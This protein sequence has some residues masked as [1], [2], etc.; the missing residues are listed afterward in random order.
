MEPPELSVEVVR[1]F[2]AELDPELRP[3]VLSLRQR[4]LARPPLGSVTI[5][6]IRARASAEFAEWNCDPEPVALVTDLTASV[7]HRRI[8]LRLYDPRPGSDTG[9]LVYLHGG[10]WMIG[11]LGLE[12]AA[13]RFMA[14]RS[15]ERILSVDYRLLPEHPFPAAIDDA[16]AVLRWVVGDGG[17]PVAAHR[18][19]LGGASAGANL[20][21]GTALKL[22]DE[23]GPT[24]C[25]LLLM[26][27]AYLGGGN[28]KSRR[29]FGDGRYGLPETM[30]SFFWRM[31]VGEDATAVNPY[32][33]PLRADLRGLPTTFINHAGLDILRDDSLVLVEALRSANVTVQH[34]GYPGAIHGF[35]QYLK[36]CGLAREALEDAARALSRALAAKS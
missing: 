3:V 22:R 8:P 11:D 4:A 17:V 18:V 27:G 31:Y 14:V 28:T 32:I 7:P 9:L 30:M 2:E 24:P 19:A 1:D 36:R 20:A 34:C 6:Q 13:L 21:I 25:F 23:R 10:G 5:E 12:D 26:Y 29:L 15:G 16:A 35:T 33:F